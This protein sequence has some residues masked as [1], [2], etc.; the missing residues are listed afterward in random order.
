MNALSQMKIRL[1]TYIQYIYIFNIV[2]IITIIAGCDIMWSI[3]VIN[4]YLGECC[5]CCVCLSAHWHATNDTDNRLRIISFITNWYICMIIMYLRQQWES[6]LIH[7]QSA[8][9]QNAVTR[10]DSRRAIYRNWCWS[11]RRWPYRELWVLDVDTAQRYIANQLSTSS[12]FIM[13]WW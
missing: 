13:L 7:W 9:S 3:I 11:G 12:F 2:I 6:I 4:S 8:Q 1:Y 10:Y 5:V